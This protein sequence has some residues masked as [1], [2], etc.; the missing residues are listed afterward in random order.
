LTDLFTAATSTQ[1]SFPSDASLPVVSG[2][3]GPGEEY[4]DP[5]KSGN[6]LLDTSG[7]HRKKHLSKNFT[8]DELARS[9]RTAFPRSR[10][11]PQL[12]NCLQALRDFLRQPVTVIDGYYTYKYLADLVKRRGSTKIPTSPH[13]SGQGAKV[14][15]KGF[16][17]LE[18]AKA[19]VFSCKKNT[20]VS[21]GSSTVAIYVEQKNPGPTSYIRS[22]EARERAIQV[23]RHVRELFY[24]VPPDITTRIETFSLEEGQR[25]V[26]WAVQNKGVRDE[27]VLAEVLFYKSGYVTNQRWNDG[28]PYRFD[29]SKRS[30]RELW[31][32][33]LDKA[34]R[35]VLGR[36]SSPPEQRGG[37]PR[38]A[39]G[40][41]VLAEPKPDHPPTNITG[42]YELVHKD[43]SNALGKVL[44]INQAGNHIQVVLSN[45]LSPKTRGTATR[46]VYRLHGDRQADGS[47]ALSSRN[48][49]TLSFRLLPRG[50]RLEFEWQQGNEARFETFTRVASAPVLMEQ[51]LRMFG[52][53]QELV[54]SYE[55]YPLLRAQMTQL[56][57]FF[58]NSRALGVFIK[59]FYAIKG[60]SLQQHREARQSASI[61]RFDDAIS[62][63]LNG[64]S[65]GIH[66][67]DVVLARHYIRLLLGA[68]RWRPSGDDPYLSQLD[69]IHRMVAVTEL[70]QRTRP[71][72]IGG[73]YI[74]TMKRFLGLDFSSVSDLHQNTYKV[75]VTLSGGTGIVGGYKGEITI[76]KI[77]AQKWPQGQ[78]TF[79]IW[80]VAVSAGGGI[81][82]NE[83]FAGTVSTPVNWLPHDFSGPVNIAFGGLSA[84][85]GGAGA[86]TTG[87][88]MHI[89]GNKGFP[90]LEVVFLDGDVAPNDSSKFKIGGELT[91]AMGRVQS[92]SLPVNVEYPSIKV[93][94]DYAVLYEVAK[95]A[96]FGF[97]SALLTPPARQV[98]RIMCA[99]ELP[100]LMSPSSTLRIVAHTDR[101]GTKQANLTLS[102]LRAA[103]TQQAVKDVLGR[104]LQARV[105]AEGKGETEAAAA[106]D[107]DGV[108]N[109]DR[110]RVDV[111]L[112][113]RVVL[114]LRAGYE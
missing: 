6:P 33:V 91:A 93:Q 29:K 72:R 17:G 13:L 11:D 21:I 24:D 92:K 81:K 32:A 77:D 76:S 95:E 34:V 7:E 78:E 18:L 106:R 101:V 3:D 51:A 89:H 35:P 66:P 103:N 49:R 105:K 63:T 4:S 59:D 23:I 58:G 2:P 62:K 1:V 42:Q 90:P 85:G 25:F 43:K 54:R 82:R 10:I 112:N 22:G 53:G 88:F 99:H 12:V 114:R 69:W 73:Y 74:D 55:W 26:H 45:V 68:N 111:I 9:G 36:T 98:L 70:N 20:Q 40:E 31:Q 38:T 48:D 61:S 109:M 100:A 47:Y 39:K 57:A 65:S 50:E 83:T 16:S 104:K 94:T 110:R 97:N 52:T 107:E 113:G 86:S 44:R 79:G 87:G 46:S 67:S 19:V 80:F 56:R 37:D 102:A 60:D 5:L 30:D 96:H 84:E 41:R 28:I 8:V 71:H 75:S 108:R 15:V 27:Q 14:S 64:P